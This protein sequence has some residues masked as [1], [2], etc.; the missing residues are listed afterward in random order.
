MRLALISQTYPPMVSGISM[1]VSQLAEGLAERGHQVLVL[2]ASE[3]GEPHTDDTP[4]LRLTRLRSFP[5]P[6]RVGQRWCWWQRRVLMRHLSAF[7]P[8]VVHLHDPTL[9]ALQVPGPIHQLG[10]PLAITVHA[11][12]IN[13]V[14]I[15]HAPRRLQR[16]IESYL[17]HLAA[18]RLVRFEAVVTPS[19]Y[20][21]ASYA[22]H[23]GGHPLAISNGVN[24]QRFHPF[25]APA[26]ERASLAER[27]GLDPSRPVIL[28]VGRI[29]REKDVDV[30]IRAAAR[31]LH[32]VD[33]QLLVVGDGN[34]RQRL[35]ALARELGV[36][37]RTVFAGFL[38]RDAL[39]HAYRLATVFA[40]STRIEAEGIVVLEA[41]ASGLPIVAVRATSMPELVERTG[42]GYLVEPGDADGMADRLVDLLRNPAQREQLKQAA[43]A[44][45]RQHSYV[46]TLDRHE[47]LYR[48]L[49][50]RLPAEL[51]PTAG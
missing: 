27:F 8:E 38:G 42:C 32:Q 50:G 10:L 51:N 4:N 28:H 13:V 45:A 40:L 5:T 20:A 46:I 48:R 11:L 23:A 25:L 44:M 17:W 3:R 29:D 12:P 16:W 7:R 34:D 43:L 49:A 18:R 21:A 15:V 33:G 31:A 9:G 41:A 26:D 36:G 39:P 37:D 22:R 1:A 14:H 2:A 35:M 6:L 24:L 19:E 47:A 30:M